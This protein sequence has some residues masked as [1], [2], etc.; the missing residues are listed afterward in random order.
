MLSIVKVLKKI[1]H[2]PAEATKK[3]E[4][5]IITSCFKQIL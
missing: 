1:C 5:I 2:V 3:T 4:V